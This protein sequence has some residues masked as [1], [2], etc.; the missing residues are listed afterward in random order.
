[1][2]GSGPKPDSL[3]TGYPVRQISTRLANLDPAPELEKFKKIQNDSLIDIFFKYLWT[4]V[5]ISVNVFPFFQ[6]FYQ[7]KFNLLFILTFW[8][9]KGI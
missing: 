5:I 6:Q 8:F 2:D 4:E 7:R 3:V 9:E 1:M